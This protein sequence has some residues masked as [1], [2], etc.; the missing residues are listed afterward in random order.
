MRALG[1]DTVGK[2]MGVGGDRSDDIVKSQFDAEEEGKRS[3][4]EKGKKGREKG[5]VPSVQKGLK[6]VPN[7][8]ESCPEN[9]VGYLLREKG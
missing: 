1:N 4:R 2:G 3:A 9:L 7:K 5:R 6:S 8:E